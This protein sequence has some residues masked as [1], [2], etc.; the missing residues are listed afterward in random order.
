[1][2]WLALPSLKGDQSADQIEGKNNVEA[3][4]TS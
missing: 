1:M 2:N 3:K 4:R